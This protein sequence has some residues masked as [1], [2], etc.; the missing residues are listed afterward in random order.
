MNILHLSDIHFGRN[1]PE[2]G[3]QDVFSNKDKILSELIDCISNIEEG[4]RPEHIVL[5]TA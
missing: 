3:I 2:Y 4:W 1:Y 5:Q